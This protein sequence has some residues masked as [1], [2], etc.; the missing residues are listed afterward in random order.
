[1]QV[2]ISRARTASAR[3]FDAGPFLQ[4]IRSD[5]EQVRPRRG[6]RA[7]HRSRCSAPGARARELRKP[8]RPPA[9][10]TSVPRTK[11]K[12]RAIIGGAL[13]KAARFLRARHG[14]SRARQES[15]RALRLRPSTRRSSLSAAS[16]IWTAFPAAIGAPSSAL[17]G[18]VKNAWSTRPSRALGAT[19]RR[20]RDAA[21]FDDRRSHRV[22]LASISLRP[23]A[24]RRT[25]DAAALEV[26]DRVEE[27]T[28]Q[29][30]SH[31]MPESVRCAVAIAPAI[32][33]SCVQ[34][35]AAAM[36]GTA[37]SAA[38]SK[39]ARVFIGRCGRSRRSAGCARGRSARRWRRAEEG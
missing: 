30:A 2:S 15:R 31:A 4:S 29:R 7:R 1:M 26:A 9:A 25:G 13:V 5:H 32:G 14:R 6:T 8:S 12:V 27:S 24:E 10:R 37:T 18:C 28:T 38:A 20:P 34:S 23:E 39:Q 17:V 22:H 21:A 19:R 11:T 3:A 35:A 16:M 33:T 36:C